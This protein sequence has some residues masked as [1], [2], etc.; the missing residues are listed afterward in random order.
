MMKIGLLVT[1]TLLAGGLMAQE[2]VRVDSHVAVKMRDGVTLY[3]DV[4]RP[5]RE[6]KFPVIVIRTPYGVQREGVH[7]GTPW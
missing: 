3:A 7:S 6:G 1:G 5:A 4:Y 2:N